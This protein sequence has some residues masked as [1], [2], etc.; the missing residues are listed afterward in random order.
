MKKNLKKILLLAVLVVTALVCLSFSSSAATEGHYTYSVSNGKA[1]ITDVSTSIS[2][3]VIIPSTLGD[4]PVTNIDNGA[5]NACAKITSITIPDSVTR[6]GRAFYGCT[7]LESI[8]LP[9]VGMLPDYM[10]NYSYFGYIFDDGYYPFDNEFVPENLKE[11]IITAPC[12]MIPLRAFEGCTNLISITIP[13]TVTTIDGY[14]FYK[15]TS[16]TNIKIPDSVISIGSS[17]FYNTV[18]YNDVSN[19]ENEVL[20]ISNHLIKANTS[21][22]DCNIRQGT[23]T[24]ASSAFNGCTGLTNITIPDGVKSIGSSAFNGCTSLTS[25]TIPDSVTSI[26]QSAFNNTGYYNELSNW[27]NGVLYIGNHLIKAEESIDSC[28]IIQSTKTIAHSAFK[29]CTGLTSITLPFVGASLYD[30]SNTYFGYIFGASSYSYNKTYVPESLK[31]VTIT[32]PC[33]RIDSYAFYGCK[34]LTSIIIPDSV[35]S[36]GSSAFYGCTSLTSI[37]VPDSVTSIGLSAFD[38]CTGLTSITL[39]FVGASQGGTDNTKFEY[40][41][42]GSA[43]VT[44]KEVIITA[45]CETI[46]AYAFYG[47]TSITSITI[48]NSV[49]SIGD[50]AFYGCTSLVSVTIPDSVTSIGNYVFY[51]CTRLTS[52]TISDSVTFIGN[53]AFYNTEY[54]NEAS[55]WENGVLYISNHLIEARESIVSCD[56]RQGTKTI[57]PF[58]FKSC[59][60]LPNITIPESVTFIGGNAFSYCS[61]LKSITVDENNINYS[62]ENGV[63]FDKTKTQLIQYPA[64]ST[65]TAYTI[66]SSVYRILNYAFYGSKKLTS[67]VIPSGVTQIEN[68]TFYDCTSLACVEIPDSVEEIG[69]YAFYKCT[70]LVELSLDKNVKHIA[71]YAFGYSDSLSYVYYNGSEKEFRRL[72]ESSPRSGLYTDGSLSNPNIIY[73]NNGFVSSYEKDDRIV[74]GSYPQSKVTDEVLISELNKFNFEWIETDG[75]KYFDVEYLEEKY[76]AV[77]GN[78]EISWY[79]FEPIVW[80][81]MNPVSGFV[82]AEKVL[83]NQKYDDLDNNYE[84]SHI[85]YW[86]NNDFYNTAFSDGHKSNIATLARSLESYIDNPIY[87]YEGYTIE[88]VFIVGIQEIGASYTQPYTRLSTQGTDYSGKNT[89]WWLRTPGYGDSYY[90]SRMRNDTFINSQWCSVSVV[91]GVRPAVYLDLENISCEHFYSP[92]ITEPTCTK[93]GYTTYSC[94]CGDSYVVDYTD[95]IDHSYT[96]KVTTQPTHLT[97]GVETFTCK[98]GDSYTKQIEKLE[99]HT[100][101][102]VK[103]SSTCTE[104]GY[105]TYTCECGDTYVDNYVDA[106]GHY[107]TSQVTTPSTHITEGIMIFTCVYC[108]DK[109]TESVEKLEEHTYS[110]QITTSPTHLKEGVETFTCA[111]GDTYTKP[112]AKLS[113]HTYVSEITKQPT[114]KE[115]GIKTFACACGAT[116]TEPVAKIPHSYNKVVT[117]PSCT[118]RGYTTY[119]CSCGDTYVGDYVGTKAHSYTSA[120]TRPATHLNTGIRT[121]TCKDCGNSYTESIAKTTQHTHIAANVVSPECE[122]EGYT[123]YVC[124]CGDSYHGDIRPASGHNYNGDNCSVCGESKVE[125]CD[126]NCHKGGF[127]GLIWKILRFFYKLFGMNKT[128]ACGVAHY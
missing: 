117:A 75:K 22:A 3:D 127:S 71:W 91:S 51:G 39:P 79:R 13:E 19:W 86:L 105:T 58:A 5:F 77:L 21:I 64:G 69:E 47:C 15:C 68:Y 43:S 95:I 56:I 122:K 38:G 18:D 24:I 96:S 118:E 45:P 98:C 103:T 65:I 114:H 70:S 4:C 111:C 16:L 93:Q 36:I 120:V 85:R 30:T 121:Y 8:T 84:T 73:E 17:A 110:S 63:L 37:I 25:I 59:I 81:V 92:K 20:Y 116:Y 32:I 80:R 44:L 34:D 10:A 46:A 89:T 60:R 109:Y 57:A 27:K 106:H 35:T 97:E 113:E 78:E 101:K 100:Y 41:F 9:F 40:I 62:S 7:G 90:V 49:T 48:P 83:D 107:Y 67:V 53:S 26:G 2:G 54:Y 28:N 52:I 82:L 76:R 12:K 126:C 115:E 14:A 55:N 31:C 1:T 72:L 112:V 74:Y 123:V 108:K 119:T 99:T 128:C 88:T 66:P 29:G 94:P 61:S 87:N 11:V 104:K 33:K 124:E 102:S 125:N 23:K 42:N 50:F 6:I